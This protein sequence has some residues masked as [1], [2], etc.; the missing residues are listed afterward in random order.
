MLS[1][2]LLHGKNDVYC[3]KLDL[4]PALKSRKIYIDGRSTPDSPS[5]L[6]RVGHAQGPEMQ[7]ACQDNCAIL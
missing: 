1:A 3:L 6:H 2:F 4:I 7:E 5:F